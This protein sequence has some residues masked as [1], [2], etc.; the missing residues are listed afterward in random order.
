M[1]WQQPSPEKGRHGRWRHVPSLRDSMHPRSFPGTTV[2]GCESRKRRHVFRTERRRVVP[3]G[4]LGSNSRF[5]ALPCRAVA[6]RAFGTACVKRELGGGLPAYWP[7]RAHVVA[8]PVTVGKVERAVLADHLENLDWAAGKTLCIRR[9]TPR[10]KKVSDLWRCR[11]EARL[12]KIAIYTCNF[13][14][15][16]TA[17]ISM[18]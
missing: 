15:Q 4:T 2:P 13:L 12:E 14:A 7:K 11:G 1:Q 16:T 6:F 9:L 8:L 10:R 3:P 17:F 5:P 18:V